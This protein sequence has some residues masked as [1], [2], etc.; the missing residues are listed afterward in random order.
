M[1][2][3]RIT[4]LIEKRVG[5]AMTYR[6]T[7]LV[8]HRDMV[9]NILRR[10]Q[11]YQRAKVRRIIKEHRDIYLQAYKV[12]PPT[13]QHINECKAKALDDLLAALNRRTT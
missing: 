6:Q 9:Y 10:E 11:A 1:K 3:D 2:A 5:Y 12:T 4:K 7:T 13:S 8:V